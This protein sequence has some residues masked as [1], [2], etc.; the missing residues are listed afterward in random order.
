MS[1][2]CHPTQCHYNLPSRSTQFNKPT[3]VDT[4]KVSLQFNTR[5]TFYDPWKLLVAT[6]FL[7]RTGGTR[8]LPTLWDFF[9]QFPNAQSVVEEKVQL[10]IELLQPLGLNR[11][12]A[13]SLIRFSKEYLVKKWRY[14]IELY[15]IGKYGND[16]YRI[17]CVNEWREV[18]LT[19]TLV[20]YRAVVLT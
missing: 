7:N 10:I 14:P 11:L 9:E 16:S 5:D 13:N 1:G 3:E 17:F 8:A 4:S 18:R 15:G 12:R 2:E 19:I 20:D 6:I